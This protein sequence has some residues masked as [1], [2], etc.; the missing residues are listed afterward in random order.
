ME[1]TANL[2]NSIIEAALTL[3]EDHGYSREDLVSLIDNA[4][5]S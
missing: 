5:D 4:L 1:E 2:E 3:S